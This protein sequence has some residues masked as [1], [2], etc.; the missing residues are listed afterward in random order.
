LFLW[1][2]PAAA[3]AITEYDAELCAT[4]QLT[5]VN[6][7]ADVFALKTLRGNSNGFHTIQMDVDAATNTVTVAA[8]AGAV[9]IDGEQLAT[10]VACKMVNRERINDVLE[11]ALEGPDR[12]CA[13]VNRL[14][15]VA[16]LADLTAAE[17]GAY[18]ARGV[19]LRFA[20]DYIAASGGEWLPSRIDDFIK[21]RGAAGSEPA[22]LEI[23][24]P[25]VRVPWD[26]ATKEFYQGTQHCKL[27]TR[28]AMGRWLRTGA[29]TSA[30]EL[31]PR[32]ALPCTAPTSMTSDVGSCLFWF[33][34]AR[35]MFC[36]DYSGTAWGA[37]EAREEC[38]LRH[39]S[40]EAQAKADNKYAGTGGVWS[41]FG[42]SNRPDSAPPV[43]TCVFHCNAGDE[44]LWHTLTDAAGGPA[45]DAMMQRACD[46]YIK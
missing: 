7:D 22:Y 36:Q 30:Q 19:Q 32:E 21:Y 26:T 28:E 39:A 13:D 45:A 29:F 1:P 2:Y 27:I 14:T 35:T 17:R 6:A 4:A 37:A 42:C 34:P 38:G 20:D 41:A 40:P 16:A 9:E 46:L 23:T 12:S 15:L 8:T 31:F 5:V 3:Q 44:T 43:G 11:L 10:H 33:A 18:E 25:S 24:A